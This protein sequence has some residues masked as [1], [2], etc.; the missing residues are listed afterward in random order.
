MRQTIARRMVESLHETAQLT[1]F[2]EV[3]VTTLATRRLALQAEN[4]TSYTDIIVFVLARTL[5]HFPLMLARL[6]T[7]GQIEIPDAI[8]IGLAVAQPDGLIVP[9]VE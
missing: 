2:T 3:D 9:V 5:Q 1:L 4:K 8:N 6:T 7:D